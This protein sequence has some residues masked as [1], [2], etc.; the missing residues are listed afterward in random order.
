M[1]LCVCCCLVFVCESRPKANRAPSSRRFPMIGH[2]RVLRLT[3]NLQNRSIQVLYTPLFSSPRSVKLRIA[4]GILYRLTMT[5]VDGKVLPLWLVHSCEVF[6]SLAQLA[7]SRY[8]SLHNCNRFG[9]IRDLPSCASP[10]R[11][12]SAM[13][14]PS[15]RLCD[16]H[17]RHGRCKENDFVPCSTVVSYYVLFHDNAVRSRFR[18]YRMLDTIRCF[19]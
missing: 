11:V 16:L 10:L 18:L 7:N 8:F 6:L 4:A 13:L 15:F 5:S 12:R 9:T 2:A 1:D 3:Q 19:T 17:G 14:F